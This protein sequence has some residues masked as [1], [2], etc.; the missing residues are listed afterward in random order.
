MKW[1]K[2]FCIFFDCYE[3]K[4]HKCKTKRMNEL[5]KKDRFEQEGYLLGKCGMLA[6]ILLLYTNRTL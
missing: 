3:V 6:S 2:W 1:D 5:P 4:G